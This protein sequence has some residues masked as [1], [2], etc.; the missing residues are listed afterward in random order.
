MKKFSFGLVF[1][2]ALFVG[3]SVPLRLPPGELSQGF[4]VLGGSDASVG[5]AVI[6]SVSDASGCS[7]TWTPIQGMGLI[8]AVKQTEKNRE[9]ISSNGGDILF[10]SVP[11]D[12]LIIIPG[13]EG[14]I[15]LQCTAI[16]WDERKFYQTIHTVTVKG[17]DPKDDDETQPLPPE[18]DNGA[19]A[20]V[21]SDYL[22][23]VCHSKSESISKDLAGL[24][25]SKLW[26]SDILAAGLNRPLVYD[27]D[28]KEAEVLVRNAEIK[29]NVS[30]AP[31]FAVMSKD[32]TFKRTMPVLFG[33]DLKKEL[34]IK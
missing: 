3:A 5:E 26:L 15:R 13:S 8:Q 12:S 32:G 21:K 18:P 22:V 31:F 20:W 16:N 25:N 28:S 4:K 7:V 11:V 33:D 17:G 10:E 34:G 1:V 23:L 14:V 30:K 27:M 2:L 9:V 19:G 24:M 6:L 29:G